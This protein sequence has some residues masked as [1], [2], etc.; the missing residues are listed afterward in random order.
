MW[1]IGYVFV[2]FAVSIAACSIGAAATCF[3][4]AR[5]YIRTRKQFGKPLAANQAL[6][7]M[8]ADMATKLQVSRTMVRQAARL[9]DEKH[10]AAPAYC[11]MAKKLATDDC[12]DI[13]N[14]AL[15]MHGGYG[16]L[17]D[18]PIE[19]YLRDVRV[20]QILEGTNQV[21]DVIVSKQLLAFK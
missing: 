18:Y 13:C 10:P 11:A 5:D 17:M 15:Q 4:L 19:R 21:M 8:L 20:H 2:N 12:F 9:L 3:N 1:L 7:F 14:K 6:S 16:Y